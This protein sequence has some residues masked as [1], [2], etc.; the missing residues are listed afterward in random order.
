MFVN[1]AIEVSANSI[2][3]VDADIYGP[4]IQ[5]EIGFRQITGQRTCAIPLYSC[6]RVTIRRILVTPLGLSQSFSRAVYGE[7]EDMPNDKL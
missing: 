6:L 1:A 2:S 7:F 4:M 3:V 5:S